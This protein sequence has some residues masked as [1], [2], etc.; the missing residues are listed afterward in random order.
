LSIG[1]SFTLDPANAVDV[2][3]AKTIFGIVAQALV[4]GTQLDRIERKLGAIAL[5]EHYDMAQLDDELTSLTT[6]VASNT[7]VIASGAAMISGFS[8][9]LAA[10]IAAAQA[11]GASPAQLQAVTDLQT[12]LDTNNATLTAAIA[13]NTPAAPEV[14]PADAQALTRK[15]KR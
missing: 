5:Q 15:L 7:T 2:E 8:A 12:A 3:F 13:T 11:A 9:Q 6:T 1:V 10:A 14:P 4:Q